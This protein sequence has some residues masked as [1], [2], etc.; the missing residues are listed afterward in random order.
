MKSFLSLSYLLPN[1]QP[2]AGRVTSLGSG[3]FS[4]IHKNNMVCLSTATA[5]HFTDLNL[6]VQC[7]K[8]IQLHGTSHK[9][10]WMYLTLLK[11]TVPKTFHTDIL[12]IG[13]AYFASYSC[14]L[15]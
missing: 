2:L 14:R 15:C 10:Q 13:A 9:T 7:I 8:T 12:K 6:F 5:E 11:G 1:F 3:H 4:H